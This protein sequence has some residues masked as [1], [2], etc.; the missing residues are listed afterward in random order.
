MLEAHAGGADIVYGV[1]DRRASDSLFKRYSAWVYYWLLRRLG[2]RIVVDHADFRLMSRRAVEALRQFVE[3]NI[4]LRGIIPLLGFR[5]DT[6]TYQ[7]QSRIAGRSKYTLWKM[8][9]L[10][11]TGIFSFSVCRYNG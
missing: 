5:S 1:R 8:I 7:R 4:F 2:A 11:F 3:V 10:A 6:V 9:S